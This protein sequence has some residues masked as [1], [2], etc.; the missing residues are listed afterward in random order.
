VDQ[1]VLPGPALLLD[2]QV[3]SQ[4]HEAARGR[5][6]PEAAMGPWSPYVTDARHEC[7]LHLPHLTESV[8]AYAKGPFGKGDQ[9]Q[10]R[11]LVPGDL[12]TWPQ[13]WLGAA[14]CR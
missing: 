7:N 6:G 10:R 1:A 5:C 8:K 3:G 4:P 12:M 2:L 13:P 9:L 11:N 14:H